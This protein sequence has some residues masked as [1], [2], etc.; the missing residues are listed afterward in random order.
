MERTITIKYYWKQLDGSDIKPHHAEYLEESATDR[1]YSQM[2]DGHTSGEL[3][4]N[5][6][7]VDDPYGDQGTDYKGWW[8]L[9]TDQTL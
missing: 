6:S 8:A 2:S 7:T 1:I 5:I 4:D 9:Q 3:I